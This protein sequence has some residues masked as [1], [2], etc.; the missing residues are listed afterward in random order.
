MRLMPQLD[1]RDEIKIF[2]EGVVD[3]ISRDELEKKIALSRKARKPLRIKYGADPSSPDLHLGHTVP[4][5]KLR[6]LQELGHQIIFLVGDFTARIGDPSQQSETRRMLTEKEVKANAETYQ[7]QVFKILDPARTEVVYNAD[8]LDKLTPAEFLTLT[9]KYT[10][11]RLL[12]RDDFK[13]RFDAKQPI[14]LLEFLYPLLQGYDSVV[15]RSDVELGGTDQKFNL[16]VGRELQRDYGQEP[17]IVITLPMLEGTDGVQKMS[18]SLGNSI[19][20]REPAKEMFGKVMSIPDSLL[21]RYFSYF[22]QLPAAEIASMQK[23]FEQ[24]KAHPRDLKVSLAKEIVTLYHNA[25]DA[26][27]SAA[28][29][30]KIFRDGGMP[31]EIQE[32]VIARHKLKEGKMDILTLLQEAQLTATKSE[33][34]RLIQQG[35]VKINQKKIENEKEEIELPQKDLVVQCGKRR[36][37]RVRVQP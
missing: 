28:E 6:A 22:T 7:K 36:F 30:D 18:K 5:R 34:R 21:F 25:E 29:F 19:S 1:I 17:Q 31:D 33:A 9:A 26:K 27:K 14:A 23:S 8:W 24:G 20:V 4:L 15:L 32:V 12:E 37:A 3:L 16:L 2:E 10:V 13:K 35:G 11:A